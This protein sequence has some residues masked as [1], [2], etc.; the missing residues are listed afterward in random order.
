MYNVYI[1]LSDLKLFTKYLGTKLQNNINGSFLHFYKTL[2]NIVNE[3]HHF[4]MN[5]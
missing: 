4:S 3:N 2:Y 1:T 5:I